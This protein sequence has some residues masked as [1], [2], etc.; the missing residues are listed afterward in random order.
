MALHWKQ[1]G[2]NPDGSPQFTVTADSGHVVL[3]GPE[4]RGP[5]VLP[6]GT[7]YD[8]TAQAIEV[9]SAEHGAHVSHQIAQQ[10]EQAGRYGLSQESPHECGTHCTL[11]DTS[12]V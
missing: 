1:I 7:E 9:A 11:T 10:H 6:D 2:T 3:T 4:A 5:V 12:G 8:V